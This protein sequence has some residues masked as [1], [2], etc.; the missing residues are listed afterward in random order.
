MANHILLIAHAPLAQALRECALHVFADCGDDI[1]VLDVP[2]SQSPEAT[3]REA[4]ILLS[5]SGAQR[6]LVLTD[7]FGATP[8]NV[9]HRLVE[10]T[11]ARLLVG[12]NLPMLLRALCYRNEPLE[13]Q[14]ERAL[15]GGQQGMLQV[16]GGSAP[17]NQNSRKEHGQ[18]RDHHQ[19]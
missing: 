19:Q 3:L 15:V 17:Q 1:S 14:T 10:G 5:Q 18:D 11:P 7:V 2:S 6:T 9:A 16:G 4:E 13:Q 8:S 12:V